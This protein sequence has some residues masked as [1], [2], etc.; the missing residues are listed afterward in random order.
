[1]NYLMRSTGYCDARNSGGYGGECEVQGSH[2]SYTFFEE[3]FHNRPTL[4][5]PCRDN[6]SSKSIVKPMA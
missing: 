3:Y 6:C 4:H 1:M 2:D 5:I